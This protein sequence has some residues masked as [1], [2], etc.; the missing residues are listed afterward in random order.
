M[1]LTLYCTRNQ[2]NI[3]MNTQDGYIPLWQNTR[4]LHTTVAAVCRANA[5]HTQGQ[6]EQV[7]IPNSLPSQVASQLRG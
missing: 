2:V 3:E 4:W 1:D 7:E 6:G 5:K